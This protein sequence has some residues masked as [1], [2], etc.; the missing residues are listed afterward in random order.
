MDKQQKLEEIAKE[1]AATK[2]GPMESFGSNPVPGEGNP[3]SEV[4][5]IGE[6]PGFH[7]NQ[8]RRPFVGVS[9]QLLRKTMAANGFNE[10]DVFITNIVKFRPPENRDP[11][12]QEIEYFRPF[13]DEQIEVIDPKF[14]VTLGRYSM[15]KFLGQ[16][17]SITRIHGQPRTIKWNGKTR[18]IFPMFHPAAALRDPHVMQTFK[19]DFAKL[20]EL[21]DKHEATQKTEAKEEKKDSEQLKLV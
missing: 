8:Q 11:T 9:G 19:D 13:L 18:I 2:G 6:A 1:I 20:K 16:G 3:D 15:Y 4:L 17:A 5:F 12:P 10:K 14:I 7:E 21:V